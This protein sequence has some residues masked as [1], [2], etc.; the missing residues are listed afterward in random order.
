M[1]TQN[2]KV[3]KC[4]SREFQ[5]GAVEPPPYVK[6]IFAKYSGGGPHMDATQLRRFLAEVQ[7]DPGC[8]LADAKRIMKEVA[9]R[10]QN[11]NESTQHPRPGALTVDDF[12][13]CL[14]S[15][16]LNQPIYP[17]VSVFSIAPKLFSQFFYLI[18]PENAQEKENLYLVNMWFSGAP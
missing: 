14:L 16:D 5:I 17:E 4:F 1:Q 10:Q 2:Y 12:F 11:Q 9:S 13:L 3:L 6:L 15:D 7:G 18:P 8:T